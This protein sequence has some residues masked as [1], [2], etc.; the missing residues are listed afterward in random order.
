MKIGQEIGAG[1]AE[2]VDLCER[3]AETRHNEALGWGAVLISALLVLT[4][5]LL[6]PMATILGRSTYSSDQAVVFGLA[7]SSTV[8]GL[9]LVAGL[10]VLSAALVVLGVALA[11]YCRFVRS[12]LF[13]ELRASLDAEATWNNTVEGE[14]QDEC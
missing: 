4:L 5:S 9:D 1:R 6:S 14:S 11:L 2:V 12:R 8:V 10:M 13:A 3:L 7:G